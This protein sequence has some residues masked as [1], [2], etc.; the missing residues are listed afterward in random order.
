MEKTLLEPLVHNNRISAWPPGERPRERLIK[1]GPENLSDAELLAIV[2]RIGRGSS[3]KN[4][5][6]ESAV[7]L[8]RR[9]LAEL[10]G[11]HGLD[12]AD[13]RDLLKR[14]GL[15]TAKVSQ[16]KAAFELGKRIRIAAARPRSFKSGLAVAAY[17]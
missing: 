14:R 3:R 2:L 5:P 1:E 9:L 8:A 4:V 6:G 10:H 16:I 13:V 17:V 7:A 11:L 15:S 12:Q